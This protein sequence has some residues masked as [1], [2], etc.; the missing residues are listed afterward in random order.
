MIY[1]SNF[2]CKERS[3]LDFFWIW[4]CAKMQ[5]SA[6][7]K[8]VLFVFIIPKKYALNYSKLQQNASRHCVNNLNSAD[9]V[10]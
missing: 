3:H 8:N 9:C 6:R 10:G 1:N 7:T 2:I 5:L 4:V